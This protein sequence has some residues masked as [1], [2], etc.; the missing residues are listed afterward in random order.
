[1]RP[2]PILALALTTGLGACIPAQGPTCTD[3]VSPQDIEKAQ[4]GIQAHILKHEG[5]QALRAVTTTYRLT[6][7]KQCDTLVTLHYG[8]R[9]DMD[10][11]YVGADRTY[12]FDL[13]SGKVDDLTMGD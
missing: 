10:E 3:Q 2:V 7:A 4:A 11:A 5:P 9:Q 8:L 13:K 1:M 6:Q 12:R